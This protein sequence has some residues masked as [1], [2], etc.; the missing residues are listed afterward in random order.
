MKFGVV[1][2]RSVNVEQDDIKFAFNMVLTVKQS[3]NQSSKMKV[4]V[5]VNAGKLKI[6]NTGGNVSSAMSVASHRG[7][8]EQRQEQNIISGKAQVLDTSAVSH[9]TEKEMLDVSYQSSATAM[10]QSMTSQQSAAY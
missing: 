9:A 8:V 6:N 1:L 2:K 7:N 3:H 5:M 10:N 4:P